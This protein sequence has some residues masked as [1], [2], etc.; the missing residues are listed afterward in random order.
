ME[1]NNKRADDNNKAI[2]KKTRLPWS[3]QF[4]KILQLNESERN[5][6][7]DACVTYCRST[8]IGNQ[9]LKYKAIAHQGQ[10][11]HLQISRKCGKFEL[12]GNHSNMKNMVMDDNKITTPEGKTIF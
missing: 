3:T 11:Q 1:K 10:Y 4:T 12:C 9:L 7:P 8:T 6:M 5:L 2:R